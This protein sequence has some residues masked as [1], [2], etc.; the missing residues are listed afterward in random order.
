MDC[1][2]GHLTT[3]QMRRSARRP[4]APPPTSGARVRRYRTDVMPSKP[5]AVTSTHLAG[6]ALQSRWIW[7]PRVPRGSALTEPELVVVMVGF[8]LR[9]AAA[10]LVG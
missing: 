2:R 6:K 4:G 9:V 7:L 5:G 10:S 1:G 8:S 3:Q